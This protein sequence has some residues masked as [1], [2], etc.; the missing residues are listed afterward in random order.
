MSG[1]AIKSESIYPVSYFVFEWEEAERVGWQALQTKYRAVGD[2]GG[3]DN[4]M[5]RSQR[6]TAQNS[7][8]PQRIR[9]LNIGHVDQH[10]EASQK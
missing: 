10:T 3:S 2:R 7:Q 1:Q 4:Q 8:I 5:Q 6:E 9:E